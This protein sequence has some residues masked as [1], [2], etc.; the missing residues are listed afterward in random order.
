[1]PIIPGVNQREVRPAAANTPY[2]TISA[3]EDAFGAGI[4]KSVLSLGKGLGDVADQ[5]DKS[6]ATYRQ[7]EKERQKIAQ[8]NEDEK[9]SPFDLL[10]LPMPQFT[11]DIS[12]AIGLTNDFNGGAYQLQSDYFGLTG[13]AAVDALPEV[14][15]N[16]DQLQSDTLANAGSPAAAGLAQSAIVGWGQAAKEAIQ[17]HAVAQQRVYDDDLDRGQLGQSR[18]A[19][20]LLYNDDENFVRQLHVAAQAR[21]DLAMRQLQ[22]ADQ[23]VE[24]VAVSAAGLA[25]RAA[26]ASELL[27]ARIGGALDQG[28]LANALSIHR[29]WQG[30]LL[31]Q[32]L[33][34]VSRHLEMARFINDAGHETQR[35][36]AE[37]SSDR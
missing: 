36:M 33:A 13:K 22:D 35:I 1:M 19:V 9:R 31:P 37:P 34:T 30:D 8:Q 29:R 10:T 11:P 25:A 24:P 21:T 16:V 18:D 12:D 3:S 32:D 4:G 28:D 20:A 7:Q 23:H 27:V 15:G 6:V 2:F 17:R 14:L 5:A 26:T